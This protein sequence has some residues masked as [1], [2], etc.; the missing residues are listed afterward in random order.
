MCFSSV[1]GYGTL[2]NRPRP[3]LR[4]STF[5]YISMLNFF[6]CRFLFLLFL[7]LGLGLGLVSVIGLGFSDRDRVRI[8]YR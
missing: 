3:F 5:R 8:R 1:C 6:R 4:K 7:G 2:I